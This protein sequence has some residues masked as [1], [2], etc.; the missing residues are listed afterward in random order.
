[1]LEHKIRWGILHNGRTMYVMR[2]EIKESKPGIVISLPLPMDATIG[3]TPMMLS[4]M[5]NINVVDPGIADI[6]P[7][8][9][10]EGHS[11]SLL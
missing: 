4:G 9:S 1:M 2:S 10:M 5:D 6:M 7:A 8:S 3:P 11:D